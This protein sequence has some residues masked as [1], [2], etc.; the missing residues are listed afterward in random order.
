L[1]NIRD[2]PYNGIRA[3]TTLI[4]EIIRGQVPEHATTKLLVQNILSLQSSHCWIIISNPLASA[5]SVWTHFVGGIGHLGEN[6]IL[7]V[8]ADFIVGKEP[9]L[10]GDWPSR[11]SS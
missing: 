6:P 7:D 4:S 1:Q 11:T 5:M 3:T 2:C 9:S 10:A 8:L